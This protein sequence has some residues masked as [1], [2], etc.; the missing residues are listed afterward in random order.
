MIKSTLKSVVEEWNSMIYC[1]FRQSVTNE[2]VPILER[3][4]KIIKSTDDRENEIEW[5]GP[6]VVAIR[7]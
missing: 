1:I 4:N 3:Q 5:S 2:T 7:M 6:I